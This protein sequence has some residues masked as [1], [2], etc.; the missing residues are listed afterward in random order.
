M[1]LITDFD[2]TNV[3]T[4]SVLDVFLQYFFTENFIYYLPLRITCKYH[5]KSIYELIW[6]INTNV[7]N[8]IP[9]ITTPRTNG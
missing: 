1:N 5:I 2:I 7:Y 9:Q 4:M 8:P 3:E 6:F